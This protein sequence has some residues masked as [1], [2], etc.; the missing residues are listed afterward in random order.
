MTSVWALAALWLGLA[1]IASLLSIWFRVSTALSEIIVGT[2]A[3]LVIGA[4]IGQAVLG[5]DESWIKFLSGIGA[6]VLTFLAG[7]ELDPAVFKLKWKEAA[8]VGLASFLFPFPFLGCAAAAYYVLGWEPMPS[9]LA[10]VA[11]STTSVAV[12]YA[13]MLEFGFNRTE[14]GKTVLAACFVTDLGTVVALGLIFAPF[15]FKTLV[16][17]VVGA[18]V[19]FI[20]P[21]LTPRTPMTDRNPRS[22]RSTWQSQWQNRTRRCCIWFAWR[23][24]RQCR[25]TS[26]KY[27][28]PRES[29]RAAFIRSSNACAFRPNRTAS[30]YMSTSSAA[31]PSA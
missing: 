2:I 9:W 16:F 20:L 6:I 29:P 5:T 15:T 1:L 18:V 30:S 14:Y 26:R 23:K 13:V 31:I 7:A 28:K 10:G 3:Q 19:F 21:W 11:M 4:V 24:S 22:G 8:A 25:S 17:L 27:A 12:V